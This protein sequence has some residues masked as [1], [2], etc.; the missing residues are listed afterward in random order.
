MSGRRLLVFADTLPACQKCGE[1]WCPK[2][3][4][5]YYDCPCVGPHNADD[6]GYEVMEINGKFYALPKND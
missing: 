4:T 6:L 2:H 3:K 5:H 1:P